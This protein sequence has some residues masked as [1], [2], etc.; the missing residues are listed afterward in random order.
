MTGETTVKQARTRSVVSHTVRTRDGGL[1][2]LKC[3]RKQAIFL[4]CTECLG[5]EDHPRDCTSPLCPL[6]PFRGLTMASQKGD[7]RAGVTK[8]GRGL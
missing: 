6:Y 7:K 2:T 1:K 8:T 4:C 5:W 3:G